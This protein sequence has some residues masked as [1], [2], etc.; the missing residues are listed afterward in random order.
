MYSV[1]YTDLKTKQ[2]TVEF[3]PIKGQTVVAQ[4]LD[5]ISD[6][7]SHTDTSFE[8]KDSMGWIIATDE[9]I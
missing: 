3:H 2:Q 9:D 1:T 7:I 5:I 4:A 6:A 8:I